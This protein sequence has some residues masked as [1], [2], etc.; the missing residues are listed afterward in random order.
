[1]PGI[2]TFLMG[3]VKPRPS[4]DA[5]YIYIYIYIYIKTQQ[6]THNDYVHQT[7]KTEHEFVSDR[8]YSK[9]MHE[10]NTALLLLFAHK[11]YIDF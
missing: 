9:F 7:T 4:A 5:V 2:T 1:M 3:P 6:A 10:D 8:H 11:E